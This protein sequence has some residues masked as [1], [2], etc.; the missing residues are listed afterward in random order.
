MYLGK[1]VMLK[2]PVEVPKKFQVKPSFIVKAEHFKSQIPNTNLALNSFWYY[3]INK[4][5][6]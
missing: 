5:H 2:I 6:F 4:L 3:I 1:L